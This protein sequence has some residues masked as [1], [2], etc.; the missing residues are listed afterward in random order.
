TELRADRWCQAA[1][2]A[3]GEEASRP[4]AA[5]ITSG[6]GLSL[7]RTHRRLRAGK[8]APCRFR[9]VVGGDDAARTAGRVVLQLPRR[10]CPGRRVSGFARQAERRARLP[11]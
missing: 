10:L 9:T 5:S 1:P 11:T 6:R 7:S 2:R 4:P 3:V 8:R